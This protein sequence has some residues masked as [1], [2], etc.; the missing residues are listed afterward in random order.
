MLSFVAIGVFM[1][2]FQKMSLG[3]GGAYEFNTYAVIMLAEINKLILATIMHFSS[4]KGENRWPK[5]PLRFIFLYTVLAAAYCA[6]N[7]LTFVLLAWMGPGQMTLAKSFSPVFA[8]WLLWTFYGESLSFKQIG[9]L[10]VAAGGLLMMFYNPEKGWEVSPSKLFF[11]YLAMGTAGTCAV[12][13][14]KALQGE[15]KPP[16]HFQNMMLYSQGIIFNFILLCAMVENGKTLSDTFEGFNAYAFV[17]VCLHSFN[18]IAITMVLKFGGAVEKSLAAGIIAIVLLACDFTMFGVD[19]TALK[20][21]GGLIAAAC[22]YMYKKVK[23][24]SGDGKETPVALRSTVAMVVGGL[25]IMWGCYAVAV[26]MNKEPEVKTVTFKA[27]VK[28]HATAVLVQ[29]LPSE[30]RQHADQFLGQGY[31]YDLDQVYPWEHKVEVLSQ[32]AKDLTA[33][34]AGFMQTFATEACNC[35]EDC[36]VPQQPVQPGA[37]LQPD[38][39]SLAPQ[40]KQ[41]G[42]CDCCGNGDC[43]PDL[44]ACPLGETG[45]N[46]ADNYDPALTVD[47][48]DQQTTAD[49]QQPKPIAGDQMGKQ[50][51]PLAA[52]PPAAA[53]STH[54]EQAA[55]EPPAAVEPTVPATAVTETAAA[56]PTPADETA[57]ALTEPESA[58]DVKPPEMAS[59]ALTSQGKFDAAEPAA[60]EVVEAK[61]DQKQGQAQATAAVDSKEDGQPKQQQQMYEASSQQALIPLMM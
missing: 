45:T 52:P 40:V 23:K 46:K 19:P 16:I 14:S 51:S 39:A 43:G 36:C 38:A 55:A 7:Q 25:S 32:K 31:I 30:Y 35:C 53:T 18:G 27:N 15:G 37:A 56:A 21:C 2:V 29:R 17:I 41:G 8:A 1:S 59:G 22:I 33:S 48:A 24:A 28:Q 20:V 4:E 26:E 42:A 12:V 50:E 34:E 9:V 47:A 49:A 44:G 58:A 11:L 10:V 54:T 13:N 5:P 60:A 57:T 6:Q 3:G 61:E